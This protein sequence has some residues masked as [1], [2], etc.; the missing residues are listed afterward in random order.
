MDTAANYRVVFS[1]HV[2]N[3]F[4][5]ET[6]R[7]TLAKQLHLADAQARKLFD[8]ATRHTLKTV[9]SEAEAKRYVMLLARLGAIARIETNDNDTPAAQTDK[10]EPAPAARAPAKY[11]PL[12]RNAL[13]KPALI[14]A[15]GSEILLTAVYALLL[16]ALLAA[17]F[18]Y[19]LFTQWA[20]QFVDNALLALA[21]QAVCFPLAVAALFLAAKPLLALRPKQYQGV[22]ISAE[23]EP[24]LHMFV[25]DVCERAGLPTPQAI[26]LTNDVAVITR[27]HRGILGF[28]RGEVVLNIGV[29]LMAG[30]NT[31]E[32]AAL[33]VQ[34]ML[35]HRSL[36]MPRM[37]FLIVAFNRWL[38]RALYAEDII[39]RGLRTGLE[40]GRF[41]PGMVHT[42]QGVF[43][44]T[45][46]LMWPRIAVSRLL[47][48]RL[49][50]R[51]VAEADKRAFSLAGSEGFSHMLEQQRLL[52]HGLEE[53]I[54]T[55]REQWWQQGELPDDMVQHMLIQVRRYPTSI[56]EQLQQQQELEKGATGDV[57]P[58]DA[59]RIK[60][61]SK[62]H[63][64]PGYDC[65]S[66]GNTLLRYFT[67]LARTMTLRYYHNRMH[68]PVTP[69]KLV[70][71]VIR[72][73]LEDEL[74]KTLDGFFNNLT[75]LELPLKL[76]L[77]LQGKLE[78]G[79]THDEWN[80]SLRQCKTDYS[81]A[82]A[83]Y[84]SCLEAEENLLAMRM[85]EL[86]L[87]ADLWRKIDE[88]KPRKGEL[89]AFHQQCRDNEDEFEEALLKLRQ[90]LKPYAN[91]L[92][93]A[94]ATLKFDSALA[95]ADKLL[96]EATFLIGVYDRIETVLPQLRSLKL[97]TALLQT[98]LSYR[99][100]RKQVKLND[101]I[102][103][104]AADIR[105]LLT[106]IR[107]ALKDV[108]NPY[109]A[110]RGGKKLMNFLLLE[111]YTEETP[112][113][114][115]DRGNDVVQRLT[116]MQKRI[117]GRLIAIAREAEKGLDK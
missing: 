37:S 85:K 77:L 15:V 72:G 13:F 68:I 16:L 93:A 114:D 90:Y 86:M 97:H 2:R 73:G 109:P 25:A 8:G 76:G 60:S 96:R 115:V 100:G 111:A 19:S 62:Q 99:S 117:L 70:H 57:I 81:R 34:S 17:G 12:P 22:E 5:E 59:Q 83:E 78:P 29:P 113:G 63:R 18:Y 9:T 46:K 87:Q 51:L 74:N 40:R 20:T 48:R 69:D 11:S 95:D 105:Q 101:R 27:H 42:L 38:H 84:G 104:Q 107:V 36:H 30:M 89:E 71:E 14:I 45:R 10:Q 49:I 56:H 67:K 116:L 92:A 64:I 32:L 75:Y 50:H 24:D 79:Q 58:T 106:S 3:G 55:L 23:Q 26:R 102:N 47:E 108:A 39:D 91:R 33:I 53:M 4:D 88:G 61:L 80:K 65:L 28:I 41:S 35:T 52:Q 43:A 7:Q 66:P 31:S 21:V 54:A 6:V 112:E 94:I 1:G 98:L 110:P 82:R 44:A 103:E